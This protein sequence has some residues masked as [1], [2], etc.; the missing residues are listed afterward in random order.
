MT[1]GELHQAGAR[2]IPG[3]LKSNDFDLI[4][5][6]AEEFQ[7][8]ALA[9]SNQEFLRAERVYVP[10]DDSSRL[11]G[12]ELRRTIELAK[13]AANKVIKT[14]MQGNNALVTCMAGL[15]RSGLISGLAL[16]KLT[17]EDPQAIIDSI[18][19]NRSVV[20]LSNPLFAK[21]V[22]AN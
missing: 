22:K 13:F 10:M 19:R 15:N 5:L 6:S 9:T 17:G 16:R 8:E 7:P 11:E 2:E 3:L 14:I 1:G 18:R 20:A 21:I 12:E 4:V